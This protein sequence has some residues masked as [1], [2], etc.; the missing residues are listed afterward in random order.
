MVYQIQSNEDFA[1]VLQNNPVVLMEF[2]A[3]WCPHCK[4]FYPTLEAASVPLAKEG[5][6]TAQT[7]VDTFADLANEYQV[8][9]IP[10]LI[11]FQNGVQIARTTGGRDEQGVLSFVQNALGSN[12]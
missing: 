12:S 3:S 8:E 7:E 9:G 10:T 4:A 1:S 6:F 2:Y 11:L 5:V